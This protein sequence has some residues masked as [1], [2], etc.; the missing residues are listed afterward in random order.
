[1][2]VSH[3]RNTTLPRTYPFMGG[4]V[5]DSVGDGRWEKTVNK[6]FF[7][8]SANEQIVGEKPAENREMNIPEIQA[9]KRELEVALTQAFSDFST[10]TGLAVESVQVAHM[11]VRR[12]GE[13]DR[14]RTAEVT[15]TLES[16]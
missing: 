13:P 12:L 14:R 5:G 9:L 6:Q 3:V 10:K 8:D 1:M 15:V 7:T 4:V 2:G 16:I 11:V